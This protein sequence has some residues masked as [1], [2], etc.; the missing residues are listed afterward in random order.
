MSVRSIRRVR[1]PRAMPKCRDLLSDRILGVALGALGA[2]GATLLACADTRQK[3][4]P[5]A[6]PDAVTVAMTGTVDSVAARAFTASFYARYFEA[7]R[8]PRQVAPAWHA[9]LD[10]RSDVLSERISVL[11]RNERAK[12]IAAPDGVIA[13]IDFDPFLGSQDPCDEYEQGEVHLRDGVVGIEMRCKRPNASVE[14]VA[15]LRRSGDHWQILDFYY[16]DINRRLSSFGS[17]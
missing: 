9:M 3:D 17:R 12:W 16:P 10:E 6:S 5:E 11:L 1:R 13:G 14:V 8:G 7:R 15:E 4:R 2:L